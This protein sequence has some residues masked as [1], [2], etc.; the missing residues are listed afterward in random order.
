MASEPN[1]HSYIKISFLSW[2]AIDEKPQLAQLRMMKTPTGGRVEIIKTVAL[3]WRE[4]GSLLDFDPDGLTLD[5]IE[6]D[7]KLW[8]SVACCEEMFQQWLRG[9]GKQP[10]TWETLIGLLEDAKKY[11]LAKKVKE[12]LGLHLADYLL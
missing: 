10:A 11:Y 4:F 6:A 9:E 7:K 8:G 5:L 3:K 1:S 2:N 12:I